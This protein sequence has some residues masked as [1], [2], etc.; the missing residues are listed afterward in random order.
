MTR[1]RDILREM[2]ER[3]SPTGE[4]AGVCGF[5]VGLFRS[6]GLEA[7][8]DEAGNFVAA[9]GD[10]PVEVVLLGHIDTVPGEI[11]VE[12]RDG[13]LYG[14]GA[15]DAKGAMAAFAAVALRLAASQA[16]ERLKLTVIGAVG[17]EGDSRGARYIVHR[18][19]PRYLVI[20]EPSGWDSVVLGYKGSLRVSYSLERSPSHS[21]GPEESAPEAAV[22]FWNRLKC[23]T[24][25]YN[26]GKRVFD[27]VSPALRSIHSASDGLSERVEMD[28]GV[29]LPLGYEP[30]RLGCQL[31]EWAEGAALRI[32]YGD[33]AV[34]GDRDTPLVR[35]FLWALRGAGARPR[36]KVKTGTS[37][38]NVVGPV[39][40]CPMLAYGPGDSS[41]D[42][43]PHEHLEL[44]EYERA[45][46]V[47]E[48]ALKI[49]DEAET[50]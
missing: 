8:A 6:H 9:V 12:E 10:G 44:E 42:H 28:V 13:A 7:A 4:E 16:L 24:D 50:K 11:P 40:R 35:S 3:Y 20:G 39:W 48:A 5:L 43:T 30:E 22:R 19:S 41:L 47:L 17:E 18:Y 21:A 45:I 25:E 38:M 14:R 33:P 46:G 23:A 31:E 34:R 37:D 2:L 29:R 36:F 32:A 26:E 49:L 1:E 27:Q 15:V